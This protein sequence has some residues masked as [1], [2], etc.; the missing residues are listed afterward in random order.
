M[1]ATEPHGDRSNLF[2]VLAWKQNIAWANVE[3]DMRTRNPIECMYHEELLSVHLM[4]YKDI[5]VSDL[6]LSSF[7]ITAWIVYGTRHVGCGPNM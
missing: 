7:N 3:P 4:Y 2:Q 5:H 1:N 6:Q